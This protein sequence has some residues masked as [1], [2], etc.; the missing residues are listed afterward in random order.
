MVITVLSSISFSKASCT[1]NSLSASNALVASSNR[2]IFGSFKMALAIANLCLWPPESICPLSP[3]IVSNP[4]GKDLMKFRA[5]AF[6]AASSIWVGLT[7]FM[8]GAP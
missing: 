7:L 5:L 3:T 2:R 8:S 1:K 6:L 4:L